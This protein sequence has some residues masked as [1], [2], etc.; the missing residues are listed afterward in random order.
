[1]LSKKSFLINTEMDIM[2][3][4][5][6][7]LIVL[8]GE[9]LAHLETCVLQIYYDILKRLRKVWSNMYGRLK[10]IKTYN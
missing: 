2:N 7:D 1:M 4:K 6:T 5:S 9:S 8:F 3:H 10:Y